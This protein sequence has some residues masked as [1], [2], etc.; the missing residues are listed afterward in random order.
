MR[1][2]RVYEGEACMRGIPFYERDPFV[3]VQ[4]HFCES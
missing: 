4:F 2:L 1:V 3:R